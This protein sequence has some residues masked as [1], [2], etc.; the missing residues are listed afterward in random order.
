MPTPAVSLA[1]VSR[2]KDFVGINDK[3]AR[4]TSFIGGPRNTIMDAIQG[5]FP[6]DVMNGFFNDHLRDVTTRR[7]NRY[8]LARRFYEGNHWN[9]PFEDNERKAVH[10][11]C[12]A[13]IDKGVDWFVADGWKVIAPEGNEDIAQLLNIVWEKNASRLLTQAQAHYGALNGDSF[14]YI[15][16]VNKDRKGN[17]LPKDQWKIVV[18]ALDP[19]HCFP[20]W[21]EPGVMD[22]ILIQYPYLDFNNRKLILRSIYIQ[23][24]KFNVWENDREVEGSPFVNPFGELNVVHIPNFI[25]PPSEFGQSD[26]ESIIP[27]NEEYNEVSN[28]MRKIIKYHAE[29][30]TLIYG[31]RA[32]QL[33][34][35]AKKVWSN[36][37]TESKVENLELKGDPQFL[38]ERLKELKEEILRLGDIPQAAFDHSDSRISNTSGLAMQLLFQPI[39]DKTKRRRIPHDVGIQKANRIILLAFQ[40]ILGLPV[41]ELADNPTELYTTS[42]EYSSPLPRDT[43]AELDRAVKMVESGFWSVAEAIRNISDVRDYTRLVLELA[44]DKRKELAFAYEQAKA[45]QG[46]RPNTASVFLGSESLTEDMQA[47]A[48]SIVKQENESVSPPPPEPKTPQQ[49]QGAAPTQ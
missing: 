32:S 40:N 44:A 7:L 36:L 43:Q 24:D 10:N 45:A 28:A 16:V 46:I 17:I 20:I 2:R 19:A 49:P 23:A 31:I 39:I 42:T 4:R 33:E 41:Q 21:A 11:Y 35:G 8:R 1:V 13:I 30:T 29:P 48:D 26:I 27:V 3:Y 9:V 12:K 15:T 47:L 38:S 34:K 5:N 25:V 37:P 22:S 6:F 14:L 18:S